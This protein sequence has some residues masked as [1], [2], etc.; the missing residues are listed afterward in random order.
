M[1]IDHL[2]KSKNCWNVDTFCSESELQ[3]SGN[4]RPY[5]CRDPPD[6]FISCEH[7]FRSTTEESVPTLQLILQFIYFDQTLVKNL[8][9]DVLYTYI[10]IYAGPQFISPIF[11]SIFLPTEDKFVHKSSTPEKHLVQN[12]QICVFNCR[13]KCYS[14]M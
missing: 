13:S 7:N 1:S 12:L 11:D 9:L 3:I 14:S 4:L 2:K 5:I 10:H 6:S 8:C